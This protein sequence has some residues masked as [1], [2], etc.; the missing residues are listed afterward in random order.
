MARVPGFKDLL[1]KLHVISLLDDV[2]ASIL[3]QSDP[4]FEVL[5]DA[6]LVL[7]EAVDRLLL[8]LVVHIAHNLEQAVFGDFGSCRAFQCLLLAQI[9]VDL[10]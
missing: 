7:T 8:V 9:V 6:D 2:H 5:L 4:P 10:F 3:T 1:C